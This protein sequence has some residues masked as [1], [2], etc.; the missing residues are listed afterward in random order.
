MSQISL[1]KN[2][3][4][5][6]AF[7]EYVVLLGLIGV[8]SIFAVVNF[9][10]SAQEPFKTTA[11]AL[12]AD[13]PEG[14]QADT[15]P[16]AEVI[17]T[18]PSLETISTTPYDPDTSGR[19]PGRYY[20]EFVM[21]RVEQG[22]NPYRH[23]WGF[24]ADYNPAEIVASNPTGGFISESISA[25]SHLRALCVEASMN[26][27]TIMDEQRTF[28]PGISPSLTDESQIEVEEVITLIRTSDETGLDSTTGYNTVPAIGGSEYTPWEG[29]G[30]SVESVYAFT[31]SRPL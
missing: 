1:L 25:S 27:D 16:P 9:A 18:P 7:V 29:P 15:E 8:I 13:T 3:T 19:D 14:P 6:A 21:V 30:Q 28:Y 11:A 26:L 31:C 12:T 22:G 24:A 20:E 10:A 4:R 17:E 23:S 2:S 5:G